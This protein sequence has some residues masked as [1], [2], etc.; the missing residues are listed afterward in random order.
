VGRESDTSEAIGAKAKSKRTWT[1]G[2]DPKKGA[3]CETVDTFSN[4]KLF[5]SL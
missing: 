2:A 1:T 3:T 5:F 4:Q